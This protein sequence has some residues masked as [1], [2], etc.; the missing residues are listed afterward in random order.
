MKI[1]KREFEL[2]EKTYIMGILNVTPD[3]FS[4]GGQF[5]DSG[6]ALGQVE[7]MISDGADLIDVGGESTRPGHQQISEE[8]EIAR[9]VPIIQLIK[10]RFEI[11]VSVDTYKSRVAKAALDA[12]ADLLND[13]W[14]FLYDERMAELAAQY[15]VPVCLMHNRSN[16]EY[17]DFVNDVAADLKKCLA[18]AK[19]HN[20]KPENII[21]D[22]G[23]G[24]GKTYEQNLILLDHLEV[25]CELGYPVLLGAS[26]KSVIGLALELPVTEREEGTIATTVL[27]AMKGCSF[28]RVHDVRANVRALQMTEAVRRAGRQYRTESNLVNS[29]EVF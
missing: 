5:E 17:D 20:I 18:V 10:E 25:V 1:G 14:G 24:F 29:Q 8:E 2:G 15:D 21:L 16:T 26:R 3:S 19:K 7:K 9:I 12:G 11:P 13:I 4:D 23:I 22:P 6:R 27:G 28:V